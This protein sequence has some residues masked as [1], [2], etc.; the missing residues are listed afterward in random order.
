LLLSGDFGDNVRRLIMEDAELTGARAEAGNRLAADRSR[1]CL[2]I[3]T[4]G[5]HGF[6]DDDIGRGKL[7]AVHGDILEGVFNFKDST[8]HDA[9]AVKSDRSTINQRSQAGNSRDRSPA[10]G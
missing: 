9:V 4:C 6:D 2:L 10:V 8:N 7:A 3:G 5:F 1:H